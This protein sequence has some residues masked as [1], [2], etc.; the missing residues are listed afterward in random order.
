MT[1]DEALQI[2]C[3]AARI[4]ADEYGG[5]DRD[6]DVSEALEVISGREGPK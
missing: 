5:L 4:W 2:V 1:H 6:G 3:E